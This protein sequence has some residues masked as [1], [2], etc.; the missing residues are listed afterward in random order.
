DT[1]AVLA[2]ETIQLGGYVGEV[3]S[4]AIVNV[5][6]MIA[7]IAYMLWVETTVAA[8]GL[9]LLV[10]Q[11]VLLPLMQ[12]IINRLNAAHITEQRA[13]GNEVVACADERRRERRLDIL[14]RLK[15]TIHLWKALMKG[16]LSL[17]GHLAPLGILLWGGMMVI[18]GEATLGIVVAFVAG[19][20]RVEE[21]VQDLFGL[22]RRTALAYVHH[23]LIR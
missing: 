21:P 13:L 7:T 2:H 22:Y 14:Y 9:V 4:R 5:T 16:L 6:T 10:P 12:R 20:Q 17:L 3:P 18:E 11:I 8:V 1:V 15:I 19:F 23:G